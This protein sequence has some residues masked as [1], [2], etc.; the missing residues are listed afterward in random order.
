[1]NAVDIMQE[2]GFAAVEAANADDA[3]IILECRKD[4]RV[5]FTDISMP[6]SIDGLQLAQTVRNRWPPIIVVITSGFYAAN[7]EVLPQ[8][9]LFFKKPYLAEEVLETFR[10]LAA[11]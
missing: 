3:M 8:G 1:M 7:E 2:A 10:G 9:S 5:L 6:G 11:L 4:I